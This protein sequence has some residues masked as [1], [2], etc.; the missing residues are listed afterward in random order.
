M[1]LNEVP[2]QVV[3]EPGQPANHD[4]VVLPALNQLCQEALIVLV[5]QR[6]QHFFLDVE[7]KG[8]FVAVVEL[9]GVVKGGFLSAHVVDGGVCIEGIEKER[10]SIFR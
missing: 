10:L 6:G 7:D 8:F 5:P 1:T 4:L 3:E 9:L 2:I